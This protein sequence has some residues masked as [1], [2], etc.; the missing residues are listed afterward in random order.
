VLTFFP[1]PWP[2]KEKFQLRRN[3]N[4]GKMNAYLTKLMM[5]H[6]IH[7]MKRDGHTLS[8]ISRTFLLNRRTVRRYLSLSEPEFDQFMDQQSE[9]KKELLA[10]EAF[11]KSKLELYPD[12]SAAQMHDWLKEHFTDLPVVTAKTV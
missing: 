5:Y 1:R 2:G 12:T 4:S 11:V 8:Q 6:E 9:R 3:L 10:Y 7:R